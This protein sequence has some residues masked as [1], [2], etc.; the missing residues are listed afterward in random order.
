MIFF[1]FS[2]WDSELT[3]SGQ[4]WHPWLIWNISLYP[5]P[6]NILIFFLSHFSIIFAH[7]FKSR[8]SRL[9]L[10]ITISGMLGIIWL[11]FC[12]KAWWNTPPKK[13]VSC[14]L[15]NFCLLLNSDIFRLTPREISTSLDESG[16]ADFFLTRCRQLGHYLAQYLWFDQGTRLG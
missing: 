7:L 9:C 10:I 4:K 5:L 3:G 2:L 1:L 15:S 8:R 16:T 14:P 11:T 12:S 13:V 6:S